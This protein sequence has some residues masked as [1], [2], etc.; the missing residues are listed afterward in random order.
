MKLLH[1][2]YNHLD[3]PWVNLIWFKYYQTR[4][5]HVAR[6]TGCFW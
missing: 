4:V 5:P 2:L 1:K 3:I 6:E